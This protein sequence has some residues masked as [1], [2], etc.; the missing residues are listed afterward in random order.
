MKSNVTVYYW[1]LIRDRQPNIQIRLERIDLLRS[2]LQIALGQAV[3]LACD[4]EDKERE[5]RLYTNRFNLSF[6]MHCC[7]ITA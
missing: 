1:N 7:H 3:W 4:L 5:N 6:L 2:R